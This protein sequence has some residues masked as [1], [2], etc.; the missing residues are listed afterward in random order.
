MSID[1]DSGLIRWRPVIQQLG[2]HSVEIEVS[3]PLGFTDQTGFDVLVDLNRP[4]RRGQ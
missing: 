1:P 2:P 3:D 4:A